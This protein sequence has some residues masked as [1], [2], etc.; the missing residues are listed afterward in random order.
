MIVPKKPKP[1]ATEEK[2]AYKIV[3]ARDDDT[4]QRCLRNCGPIARDHRRNRS[5]GGLTTPANLH[6][7]GLQCHVWA[8]EHPTDAVAEGWAVPGFADPLVWPGRRYRRGDYGIVHL[9]WCLYDNK[10]GVHWISDEEALRRMEG[11]S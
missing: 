7:L 1:T 11:L 6:L 5:Q 10:G 8:T 2:R 3:T 9:S 4:C